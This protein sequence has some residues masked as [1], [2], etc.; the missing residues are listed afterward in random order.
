MRVARLRKANIERNF[1]KEGRRELIRRE[2]LKMEAARSLLIR[3][4]M[5]L[6]IALNGAKVVKLD[7][8]IISGLGIVT[9]LVTLKKTWK[10]V[11]A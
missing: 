10:K 5:N 1:P 7:D 2:K 6:A 11:G 9:S 8:G 4:S 3:C